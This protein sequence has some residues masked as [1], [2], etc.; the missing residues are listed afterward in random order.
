MA[1]SVPSAS[2]ALRKTA[3]K[4]AP[5]SSSTEYKKESAAARVLGAGCAG[6][7]ELA[8]FHP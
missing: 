8:V 6:I 1:P 3:D 7:A 4:V 5:Q 2:D